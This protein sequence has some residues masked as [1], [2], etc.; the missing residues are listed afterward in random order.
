M[1][2]SDDHNKLTPA[3]RPKKPVYSGDSEPGKSVR[4][5]FGGAQP[6]NVKAKKKLSPAAIIII[7]IA[8]VL[9]LA[10]AVMGFLVWRKYNTIDQDIDK[11][12]QLYPSATSST[13]TGTGGGTTSS[14]PII[15]DDTPEEID[16][17]TGVIPDFNE[18]KNTN[19]DT[20]GHIRIPD[21]QLNTPVVQ[22][23]DNTYYLN[24]NFYG[25]STLG[26]PFLDY[27]ATVTQEQMS[28]NLTIYGHAAA[29]GTYFA[30][31]KNY[32]SLDY[33][34]EH[35]LIY[36]DTIYGKGIYKIFGAFT[37]RVTTAEHPEANAENFNYHD[38]INMDEEQFDTYLAE[39]AKRT[40]F[41]TDVDV[42][43]GDQ[44][45]T[46]STC[47][48]SDLGTPFRTVLV[49]R[50]VRGGESTEVDVEAATVNEDMILPSDLK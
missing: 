45:I 12:N 42:V 30:A 2:M 1:K 41:N 47:Y 31:V 21:T 39:I 29:N 14:E 32:T 18:L 6:V 19:A 35:P 36:F 37:A 5:P 46:L 11:S 24:H 50:K 16:P 10:V 22:G 28:N 34:K 3:P 49:A 48:S 43:Y 27:R 13:D 25:K 7:I 4:S 9:V 33:Y 20:I 26:V 17:V 38:Y 44:I 15:V 23:T 8:A 40:Y